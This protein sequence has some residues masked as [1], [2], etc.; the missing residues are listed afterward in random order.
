[1]R[2]SKEGWI[3]NKWV[4]CGSIIVTPHTS[5]ERDLLELLKLF[6]LNIYTLKKHNKPKGSPQS[7]PT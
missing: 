5:R 1:M 2:V 7:P 4:P 3:D 6:F